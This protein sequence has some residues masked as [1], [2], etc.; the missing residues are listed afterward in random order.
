[1]WR[2]GALPTSHPTF[3]L[4]LYNHKVRNQLHKLGRVCL[5][6]QDINP[7][8]TG[9]NL[10]QLW[11]NNDDRKKLRRKL[12]TLTSNVPGTKLYWVSK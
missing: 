3:A 8:I 5:N 10:K 4:V 2:S 7:Y 12:F 1:M 9:P 6:T 11:S